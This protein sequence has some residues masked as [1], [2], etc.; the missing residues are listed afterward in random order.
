M[1]CSVQ[2]K[3]RKRPSG[4][5]LVVGRDDW[6]RDVKL[7]RTI[8]EGIKIDGLRV[9]WE[10]PAAPL[11]ILKTRLE[12]MYPQIPKCINI[13]VFRLLRI[14]Y[15]AWNPSY[16]YY[17]LL[18]KSRSVE[19]R[20]KWLRGVLA[21]FDDTPVAIL[22][23]SSGARASTLVAD[24]M[25]VAL[26]ICLGYPFRKPGEQDEP[27]RYKHLS[28]LKTETFIYQGM[29][30]EY[31]GIGLEEF[32]PLSRCVKLQYVD[33]DHNF[34][35]DTRIMSALIEKMTAQLQQA[36]LDRTVKW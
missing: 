4:I 27:A 3:R 35:V 8:I 14:A 2:I 21:K 25:G 11:S 13:A 7:N 32:Y 28:T 9:C 31:G 10:D 34:S 15:A 26:I 19:A 18:S 36:L 24:E 33:T 30:D 23:R 12:E 20:C 1:N 6:I 17:I 22:A 29:R 5:L 16:I